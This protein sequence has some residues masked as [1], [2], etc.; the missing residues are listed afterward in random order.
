M[1]SESKLLYWAEQVITGEPQRITDGG[2]P[3]S[4]PTWQ[5]IKTLY[6]TDLE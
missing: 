1:G 6:E 3:I 4:S 5:E 2:T